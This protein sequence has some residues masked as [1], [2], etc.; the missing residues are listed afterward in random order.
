MTTHDQPTQPRAT[1]SFDDRLDAQLRRL[2]DDAAALAEL[3]RAVGHPPG[4]APMSWPYV[5][6]LA[7]E[8]SDRRFDALHVTLTLFA[9][10]QQ[11]QTVPMHRRDGRSLGKAAGLLAARRNA[12][13]GVERRFLAAATSDTVGELALHARGL[14]TL[15]RGE[16]IWLDYV[17]LFHDF[18]RWPDPDRRSWVRRRWGRDFYGVDSEDLSDGEPAGSVDVTAAAD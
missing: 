11:A 17:E 10:H 2:V 8:S 12:S 15:L 5:V 4:D 3:R 9:L 16:G 18:E 6:P 7:G 13:Q 14:V 1:S